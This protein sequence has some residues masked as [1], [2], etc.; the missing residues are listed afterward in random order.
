MRKGIS[1]VRYRQMLAML[2]SARRN[3]GLHQA[4]VARRLGKPQ[5]F[6]SRYELGERRLDVFEFID[7]AE[8]LGLDGIA[9]IRKLVEQ[10][11][12]E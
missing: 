8:A 12:A 2:I 5:Q 3:A 1:D 9:E 7:V 6:V 11:S 10:G 4:D